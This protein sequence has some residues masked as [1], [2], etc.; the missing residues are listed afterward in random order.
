MKMSASKFCVVSDFGNNVRKKIGS[1]YLGSVIKLRTNRRGKCRWKG[2]EISYELIG[3][4]N[5]QSK[6][7]VIVSVIG[8][9]ELRSAGEGQAN[10]E[11]LV[12]VVG[13]CLIGG[14]RTQSIAVGGQPTVGLPAKNFPLAAFQIQEAKAQTKGMAV[15]DLIHT[16]GVIAAEVRFA[17]AG[18]IIATDF[19][20]DQYVKA[21]I[22]R[23]GTV[24]CKMPLR[25]VAVRYS[26]E[27]GGDI[28]LRVRGAEYIFKVH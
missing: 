18:N 25:R 24:L 27:I 16:V 23:A 4:L 8:N 7:Q 22:L 14:H 21:G 17:V 12:L 13:S 26:G 28:V 15:H 6:R 1:A 19:V 5:S 2:N 9:A 3:V 10:L 20:C 11:V